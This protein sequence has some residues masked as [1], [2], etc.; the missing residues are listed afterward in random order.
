MHEGQY[1]VRNLLT[2][3]KEVAYF[4]HI[5]SWTIPWIFSKQKVVFNL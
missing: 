2:M 5:I 1:L 3:N 4:F